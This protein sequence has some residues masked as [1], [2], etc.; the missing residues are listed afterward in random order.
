MPQPHV[1]L[2][3][4]HVDAPLPSFGSA[5]PVAATHV[6]IVPSDV[7]L[8]PQFPERLTQ[9]LRDTGAD[10]AYTD[11]RTPGGTIEVGGWSPERSRWQDWTG[12]VMV[13][14]E[15]DWRQDGPGA[16]LTA[17][18]RRRTVHYLAEPLYDAPRDFVGPVAP[19][20]RA[21][22]WPHGLPSVARRTDGTPAVSLVIPTAGTVG[23]VAGVR[24]RWLD[25]CLAS[26]RPTL[27]RGD[28]E[29]AVVVGP[30]TSG[31]LDR[32]RAE[33]PDVLTVVQVDRPFNFSERIAAG[34]AATRGDF[35]VMANDD[36]AAVSPD[37]LDRMLVVAAQPDVGA[38]G[39]KLLYADGTIQ[40]TGHVH[41]AGSVYL[42]DNGAADDGGLRGRNDVDRDVTGVSAACLVQRREVWEATGGLDP[43][44]PVAFNDVD[45]CER[46]KQSGMRVVVCNT[47]VLRHHESRTRPGTARPQDVEL[48][49]RRWRDQLEWDIFTPDWRPPRPRS[50]LRPP[51]RLRRPRGSA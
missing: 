51:W 34:V 42:L 19:D 30:G 24:V 43:A 47:A 26:L 27:A 49:R 38:V 7:T 29:V 22:L 33:F 36:V 46:V 21:A 10:C 35:L 8:S 11:F 37:W 20:V 45:Y 16:R 39:A 17:P 3:V 5:R 1:R 6:A 48:L 14:P 9:A 23:E 4:V 44:F 2:G 28:T 25:E 13:V 50:R 40:H 12:P 32:W 15:A 41:R 31:Y 18:R